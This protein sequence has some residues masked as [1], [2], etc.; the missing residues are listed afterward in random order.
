MGSMFLST[1]LGITHAL[2]WVTACSPSL[3]CMVKMHTTLCNP[4]TAKISF[5]NSKRH[6]FASFQIC[7][8]SIVINKIFCF[9]WDNRCTLGLLKSRRTQSQILTNSYHKIPGLSMR[10]KH[11][12][13]WSSIDVTMLDSRSCTAPGASPP[14]RST[15]RTAALW[16]AAWRW[17]SS[18]DRWSGCSSPA[19]SQAPSGGR[20]ASCEGR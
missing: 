7:K 12:S 4:K 14:W 17:A 9:G 11:A 5:Q 10:E 20:T 15:S 18:S 2:R 16:W 3:S 1:Y 6:C 8:N 19:C 13:S